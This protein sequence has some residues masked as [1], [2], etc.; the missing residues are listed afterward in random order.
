MVII[1]N[2]KGGYLL[3]SIKDKI[4]FHKR[5]LTEAMEG[6]W[7]LRESTYKKWETDVF[8]DE[9]KKKAGYKHLK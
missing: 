2:Q 6:N 7:T 4:V 9:V 5:S 8:R 3:N 1:N